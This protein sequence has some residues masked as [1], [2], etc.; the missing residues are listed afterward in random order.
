VIDMVL[1]VVDMLCVFG[2]SIS[3]VLFLFKFFISLFVEFSYA[4]CKPHRNPYSSYVGV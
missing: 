1:Q 3:F 2:T 4:F